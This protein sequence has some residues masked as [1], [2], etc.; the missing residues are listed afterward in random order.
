MDTNHTKPEDGF[1]IVDFRG[2][3]IDKSKTGT[4]K[5]AGHVY[6]MN[7]ADFQ[8]AIMV[9]IN[10]VPYFAE[11]LHVP[12]SKA[13]TASNIFSGTSYML[14]VVGGFIADSYIGAYWTIA[15]GALIYAVGF[16]LLTFTVSYSGLQPE[17]C[18]PSASSVCKQ[19]GSKYM[20]PVYL[21]Y[22]VM[23]VGIGAVRANIA[24]FGADQFDDNSNY[25]VWFYFTTQI[26]FLMSFVFGVY[27]VRDVSYGWG[28]G[29]SVI[30]FSLFTFYFLTGT[31]KY[32]HR[33]PAGSF[34]TRVAQV[35]VAAV[36]KSHVN[37]PE[38][39]TQLFDAP[40]AGS[41]KLKHSDKLRFLDNAAVLKQGVPNMNNPWELCGVS[42][43]EETK[44]IIQML[45][46]W[47]TTCCVTL[48]FSQLVTFTISQGATL[49]RRWGEHFE[50]PSASLPAIF[51]IISLLTVPVYDRLFVPLLRKYTKH[52]YG[53]SPLQRLGLSI[54]SA[55]LLMCVA[56]LVERKRVTYVKDLGLEELPLGSYGLPM[57][58]W[59]LVPQFFFA[60]MVELFY[61]LSSYQFFYY[62]ASDQT[63]SIASSLTYSAS[64]MGYYL[65]SALNNL[66]NSTTRYEQ[67]GSWLEGQLNNGGLAKFF[68]LLAIFLAV[69]FLFFLLASYWYE[70]KFDWYHQD[71]PTED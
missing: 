22:Y 30:I 6:A 7:F 60:S 29:F 55:I 59:W 11:R 69:D 1:K 14:T 3:H 38:D 5:A 63:K 17:E 51:T 66:V 23:A 26:A 15:V 21:A 43:V 46:I 49:D 12:V 24:S 67:G 47:V 35:L 40:L 25:Y 31:P 71:T 10:F 50:V 57:S 39:T 65:S 20:A 62:E 2:R 64:A 48:V 68:W 45:P 54:I 9:I 33:V 44:R 41:R 58:M 13:A 61:Y 8:A 37:V 36:R 19:A 27:L 56:A 4:W 18:I 52:P 70:Y 16:G 28:F 32:R 53:L 34:L 42:Q